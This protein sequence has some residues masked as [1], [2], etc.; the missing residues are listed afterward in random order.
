MTK[1]LA[2]FS[3]N[4]ITY[5]ETFIQAHK[6]LPFNIK[7]YYNGWLP[8]KLEGKKSIYKH[9]LIDKVKRLFHK[10]GSLKEYSLI[11]SLKSEKVD[12]VLAEY[13]PTG[14]K[15]LKIVKHLKLPLVVHFHG[16]DASDK[17]TIE[18]YADEYEAM[19]S[20]A[21][22][23]LV[24]SK[25]MYQALIKL[26]CPEKKL[27][28]APYGPNP[29]FFEV[30]PDYESRQ[31]LAVGRFVE[32]KAPDLT[33]QAFKNVN[34]VYP[35]STLVMVGEGPL[36]D[37][38]KSLV[39]SLGLHKKVIFKNAIP[40]LEILPLMKSSLAFV[41]HSVVAING[42]SE[43]TPVAILEAQAAAMPVVATYHAGIPDVVIHEVT[44]LL[45]QEKA[46]A[47]M[48]DAMMRLLANTSLAATM[49]KNGR[50]K[51]AENFSLEKHLSLIANTIY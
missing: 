11:E 18:E 9:G 30:I 31:F 14:C 37:M 21:K 13:G 27:V 40:H 33:I 4:Q 32:K 35:D 41:Q 2:I 39:V 26:G 51:I 17:K 8:D 24:V 23:V 7:F 29:I 47:E 20:Y 25:A 15:A 16:F 3:P 34:E 42:D 22:A 50:K 49:G 12:A 46:I 10:A 38:C 43:G 28:L 44:G 19:F 5:S 36:L 48:A 45:V 6:K 1:T